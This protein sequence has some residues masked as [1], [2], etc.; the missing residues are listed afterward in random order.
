LFRQLRS[1]NSQVLRF[2]LVCVNLQLLKFD[3]LMRFICA[4]KLAADHLEHFRC[5]HPNTLNGS[6]TASFLFSLAFPIGVIF[7]LP[8]FD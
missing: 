6:S 2:A 5:G 7:S 1:S 8:L 3:L 4:F